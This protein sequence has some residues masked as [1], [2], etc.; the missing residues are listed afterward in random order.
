MTEFAPLAIV[1]LRV[2]PSVPLPVA[3]LSRT[4]VA[5]VTLAGFP[6]P[7]WAWTVTLK[8]APAVGLVGLIEVM[9]S[10]VAPPALYTPVTLVVCPALTVA[11]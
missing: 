7:S 5:L 6:E 9:T 10:W 11:I 1:P 3:R 4:P 2:P 8:L